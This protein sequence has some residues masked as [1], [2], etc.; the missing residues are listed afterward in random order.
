LAEISLQTWQDY[1]SISYRWNGQAISELVRLARTPCTFGGKRHWFLCPGCLRRG[2]IL[3]QC[4]GRF[5]C[6]SCHDLRYQSQA[7]DAIERTWL[8]QGK[9]ESKMGRWKSRPSGMH[10]TTH[11]RLTEKVTTVERERR[12]LMIA[13]LRRAMD[14]D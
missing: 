3:Y 5:R 7:V 12:S 8:A 11:E 13:G 9:V 10:K 1:V 6:R 2:A 14:M 4:H